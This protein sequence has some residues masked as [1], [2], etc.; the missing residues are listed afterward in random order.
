MT[1][2]GWKFMRLEYIFPLDT[3]HIKDNYLA[4]TESSINSPIPS[5]DYVPN[6]ISTLSLIH[7][8]LSSSSSGMVTLGWRG[9]TLAGARDADLGFGCRTSLC[10]ASQSAHRH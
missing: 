2:R 7:S 4:T 5:Q 1:F 8:L 6:P 10:S 3:Y 9:S